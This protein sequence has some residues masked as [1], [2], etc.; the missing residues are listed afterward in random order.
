MP[1]DRQSPG[2]ETGGGSVHKLTKTVT[3]KLPFLRG[4][5]TKGLSC[6]HPWSLAGQASQGSPES[7][8]GSW[9]PSQQVS[10]RARNA[11]K[12]EARVLLQFDPRRAVL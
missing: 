3:D 4:C 6:S 7:G 12:A 11:G 5:Q 1:P 9:L 2:R 8:S 10:M